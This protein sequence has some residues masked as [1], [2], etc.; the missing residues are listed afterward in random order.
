[1]ALVAKAF[2]FSQQILPSVHKFKDALMDSEIVSCTTSDHIRLHGL[3]LNANPSSTHTAILIHGLGGNFYSSRFLNYLGQNYSR[4]GTNALIV[5]TRGHDVIHTVSRAGRSASLGAAYEIVSECTLDIQAW[6]K[7][8]RHRI[9]GPIS[10]VGHSLGAIKSLFAAAHEPIESLERVIA[11]SATRLNHESLMASARGDRFAELYGQAERW[12]EE[13]R[14]QDLMQIDFPF[15]TWMS[16]KAYR[17]KYGPENLYDWL[18]F[19]KKINVPTALAFG[20]IEL[21]RNP[22]FQGLESAISKRLS[23]VKNLK[24]HIISG[25]D[26]FYAGQFES[27]W[28]FISSA[29]SV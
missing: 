13:G 11:F 16:A 12:V 28:N 6:A 4:N 20:E 27:A 8:T 24:F 3:F 18:G 2:L 22:A 7:W 5:N 19:V 9:G 1:M 21:L 26:H 14:G 23:D 15:P 25:A 17:L 29:D 10:L